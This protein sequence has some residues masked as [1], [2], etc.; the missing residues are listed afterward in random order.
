M[1]YLPQPHP[2]C[3][4]ARIRLADLTPAVLRFQDGGCTTGTLEVMSLTGGLLSL[5]RPVDRGSRVKLM[6]LTHTGPVLGSAEMLSPVS[7]SEQPFRFV[8]LQQDDHRRL[9]SAIQ[10]FLGQSG[11]EQEWIDKYRAAV[12]NQKP[13]RT[14][15]W[16][17]ALAAMAF[18]M[19][20]LGGVFY[21]F[22]VHLR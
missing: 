6:F 16:R 1:A 14:R 11:N 7:S 10:S 19:L 18:A 8:G 22:N 3:R 5:A 9:R 13:P 17:R 21:F 20:C 12:A 2:S 15:L 4:A